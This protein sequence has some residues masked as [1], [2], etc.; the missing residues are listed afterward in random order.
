MTANTQAARRPAG[1]E[2]DRQA[3]TH[4]SVTAVPTAT[5][6][7]EAASAL[8]A[9]AA[10][11][12]FA[13]LDLIE[14]APADAAPPADPLAGWV[15]QA[16][17]IILSRQDPVTGLLP[18]STAITVHGDYTHAWVRDN[19]YSILAI[20]ALELAHRERDPALSAELRERVEALM[21]GLLAAMIK[22]AHKVERFKHSQH[23]LDALHAKYATTT[24]DPVVGDAEWGHLQID[25]TAI[26][27]LQLAQMSAS[28]LSIVRE[29]H[30]V[31]F[32]QNLVHYLARAHRTPD[33]GIWERGHKQ[34]QGRAEINASSVGMAKA[35]LEAIA[36]ADLLPGLAP[37]ILVQGDDIAHARSTLA[38]LLPR[39]SESKETDAAL[40]S[41][42]GYPA[43]AVDDPELIEATR[44]RIVAKLQGRYG[45]KRFLR[46]GHQTVVEDHSRLHYEQGELQRFRRIES[47]WPL[48][49][50]YLLIDARLREDTAQAADYRERLDALMV[51]RDGQRLLPELYVVPAEH[52]EAERESPHSQDR[53]PNDNVPLVWAQSLYLVGAL[54]QEGW[55]RPEQLDPLNRQRALDALKGS[56][57]VAALDGEAAAQESSAPPAPQAT[58]QLALLATDPLVQARLAVHGIQAQTLTEVRPLVEVRYADELDGLLTHLGRWN[59][60]GLSG[61]PLQRLGALATSKVYRQGGRTTVFLPSLFNRQGFYLGLDN[62][63]L[64]DEMQA[65]IAWLGRHARHLPW[66]VDA[67]VAADDAT[68]LR[69]LR[70]ERRPTRPL[71]VVLITQPMLDTRGADS[72]LAWLRNLQGPPADSEAGRAAAG[73]LK[74]GP[75]AELLPRT[76]VCTADHL[77]ALPAQPRSA[78]DT[79]A[80]AAAVLHWEEAATRPL[81][82]ARAAALEREHD[83]SFHQR[84][85]ARSRNPYEQIEVLSLLSQRWGLDARSSLGGTVREL[86]EAIYARAGAERRW[87][88]LRRA[89]AV[90]DIQDETLEDAVSQIVGRGKQV[91]LGRAYDVQAIIASP[92]GNA[93]LFERL[94]RFGG[95]DARARLLIQELV[96]LLGTMIKA[97]PGLFKGTLT[98][99]PWYLLLLITG[100]LALEHAISQAEAFDHL[101]D[102]SPQALMARLR[103]VIA[104]EQEMG[105]DLV[106]LQSLQVHETGDG[107]TALVA[108]DFSASHDPAL[109][110]DVPGWLAWR[111]LSGVLTRVPGDFHERIWALLRQVPGLVI[112][113]QL[114]ARNRL[115]STLARADSTPG[116]RGFA[117]QVEDLLEKIQAPE[118]RQ[119]TI[120]ALLALS[121]IFRANADLRLG[122]WLVMD[123]LIGIAVRLGWQE[124]RIGH[125]AAD[126]NEH[127][128]QAW[129][130]F[131]AN[132]P[133]RV[134]NLVMAAVSYLVAQA[135]EEAAEA[136]A[137]AEKLA[138]ENT[139]A[140]PAAGRDGDAI[141]AA[142]GSEEPTAVSPPIMD[143]P[144]DEP[145]P[146]A[147]TD[148]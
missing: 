80:V 63:L 32:V 88:V 132:P 58:V 114:D 79:G 69:V 130:E 139:A 71:M 85:L 97:D 6:P 92:L 129:T 124:R 136:A 127:R 106:R 76:A 98:L 42:I 78:P 70:R 17:Q 125:V 111:E 118:Y 93:E 23:P 24:G 113:D 7:T 100:R 22:Q 135:R 47:E 91:S 101:L 1:A 81:S 38:A 119:L 107:E 3:S 73:A 28:G 43:F 35:A 68:P 18:A 72:L 20:W 64:I 102:C 105:R 121:D 5:P 44:S 48:F 126:Y 84:L 66:A 86:A 21:R 54:L 115:D 95:D 138:A 31:A 2:A 99:R 142:D 116:E 90:L 60:L 41:V 122:S 33:Y 37:R 144:A 117:L 26:F 140:E 103:E 27:L 133:H 62:G 36:D 10:T 120:E 50:T 52:I 110:E 89:A 109:P 108:V 94:R 40:L 137:A 143:G 145:G 4:P 83:P 19:V 74:V 67:R 82:P 87:G 104:R 45:C 148:R 96:L 16:R 39:E 25:A 15:E 8:P 30:E 34:N 53:V 14:P 141:A 77:P 12:A 11:S 13:P 55:V 131:Y 65:E 134:A 56:T 46:D 59:D 57:P 128:A 146:A 61:R 112:G 29:P 147:L 9:S 51:E 49:F 123:V 75:L